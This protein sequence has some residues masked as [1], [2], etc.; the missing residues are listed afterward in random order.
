MRL[1]A[2]VFLLLFFFIACEKNN[3]STVASELKDGSFE[4]YFT[5]TGMDTTQVSIK[6]ENNRFEGQSNRDHY[7]A[8]CHGSYQVNGSQIEF[9]DSCSWTANFNWTLI[10]NGG[11]EVAKQDNS[12][13]IWRNNG[14]VVDE[15]VLT[16]LIR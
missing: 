9:R 2:S 4:G 7:P 14:N 1:I 16:R 8:I 15:Y 6:F 11:Y 5:R 10:L 3:D 12:I 13:R